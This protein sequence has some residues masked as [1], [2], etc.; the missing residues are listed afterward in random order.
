MNI[1]IQKALKFH[2]DGNLKDA[3]IFY[4]KILK[5]DPKLS[6]IH[7]NLGILLFGLGRFNEAELSM[8]KA[9]E[10]KPDYPEAYNTLGTVL[11]KIKKTNE[12]EACVKKALTLKKDF[13]E[14]Y[15]NLS[16]I[17]QESGRLD[18]ADEIYKKS[19]KQNSNLSIFLKGYSRNISYMETAKYAVKKLEKLCLEYDDKN[20][21]AIKLPLAIH[22]FLNGDLNNSRKLVNSYFTN[23]SNIQKIKNKDGD[24]YWIWLNYLL[25]YH[26][27]IEQYNETNFQSNT[28]YVIGDSHALSS[29]GIKIKKSKNNFLSKCEWIWGCKQWHLQKA[30]NNKFKYKFEKII[31]SIPLK[32]E[33]LMSVGEIDCRINE[34]ILFYNKK[35]P[36]EDINLLIEKTI[37]GYLSYIVDTVLPYDHKITIQGIPCPNL[38]KSKI[39]ELD[40]LNLAKLIKKFNKVLKTKSMSFGFDFLDLGVITDNGEGISNRIWHIDQYHIS[41]SGIKEAWQKQF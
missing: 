22:Y 15:I 7:L 1:N 29:Y 34:G 24:N 11:H 40:I 9:I 2:K 31:S 39:N 6:F 10:L 26:E 19:I 14:A 18:E 27:K 28:L 25:D 17:L 35:N 38:D 5:S 33:I 4:R 12:A 13:S 41:P 3:E 32:S 21:S 36:K 30:H 8:M 20:N 23:T 16:Y 37:N